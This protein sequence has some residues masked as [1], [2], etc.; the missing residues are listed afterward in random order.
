[1]RKLLNQEVKMPTYKADEWSDG[2]WAVWWWRWSGWTILKLCD[3][4]E[5]AERLAAAMESDAGD[6]ASNY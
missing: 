4:Q 6:F 1:M 3:S 5:A 2:Q